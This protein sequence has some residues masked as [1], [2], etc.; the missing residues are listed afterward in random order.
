[1]KDIMGIIYTG[2]NDAR[3]RELTITRA[4]AAMP[5]AGRFRVIDFLVSSMVNGGMKNIGVIMQKNYHSLMDHLGSGKEWDL[6]GKHE[7]L[8]ILPPFLTRENVGLYP[9]ILDALRSNNS[10]LTR[11]KQETLVLSNS[12]ILYNARLDEL[13]S[14]YRETGADI[15]LMYTK[16]PTMIR[17]EYG[18][19]IKVE[20]NGDVTDM[21][22][23]PTHPAYGNC[24]MQVFVMKRELLLDLVDKAVAHGLHSMDKDIF[25]RLIQP[26]EGVRPAVAVVGDA[27]RLLEH[28]AAVLGPGGDHLLD[29]ALA[30]HGIAVAP[31]A[32]IHEQLVHVP[33]AHG[34]AVDEV[35][36]FARAVVAP[37]DGHL[38]FGAVQRPVGII[39]PQGDLRKALRTALPG[40]GEDDVLHSGPAKGFG[41][42]L[43]QHPA[44]G[45]RNIAFAEILL[46]FYRDNACDPFAV[47]ADQI[48]AVD[49]AFLVAERGIGRMGDQIIRKEPLPAEI[50]FAVGV[51]DGVIQYLFK[52][53]RFDEP[54]TQ[55]HPFE[56]LRQTETDLIRAELLQLHH[57]VHFRAERGPVGNDGHRFVPVPF[58]PRK[59]GGIG[60]GGVAPSAGTLAIRQKELVTGAGIL[61]QDGPFFRR[62]VRD[63]VDAAL[64]FP[65]D[66]LKPVEF[67]AGSDPVDLLHTVGQHVQ[68]L[69]HKNVIIIGILYRMGK[70]F[71]R[72]IF[73]ALVDEHDAAGGP[74]QLVL[75]VQIHQRHTGNVAN[76]AHAALI[77]KAGMLG[78]H[79]EQ[80]RF[81]GAAVAPDHCDIAPDLKF[82]PDLRVCHADVVSS[83]HNCLRRIPLPA[84]AAVPCY[85]QF[86]PCSTLLS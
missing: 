83:C 44:D 25:L 43:P 33:Q 61:G 57:P 18:T 17:D 54:G 31:Q 49:F 58:Q 3:L 70:R 85:G 51:I 35:G 4:I 38:E 82:K 42:L 67:P 39:Q 30:H 47:P 64:L 86:F 62:R 2:E 10:Y 15:T 11:S 19:Y 40:T 76:D 68:V 41:G 7:G 74:A 6:H 14:F 48:D 32:R 45:V 16:D 63:T 72:R 60:S 84:K 22:V 20:E 55:D 65:I 1:M 5:V 81:S 59:D 29:L 69:P 36:A 50:P 21:E 56:R 66:R 27:R 77:R 9:G 13:I 26:L 23:Q 71:R 79:L 73:R 46:L 37:G 28:I 53:S 8:H 12:N 78:D 52:I 34:L 24:Y 75:P 80:G